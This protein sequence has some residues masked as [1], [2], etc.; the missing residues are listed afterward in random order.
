MSWKCKKCGQLNADWATTCGRC[1]SHRLDELLC[2]SD[3][4]CLESMQ[5]CEACPNDRSKKR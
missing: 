5:P 3:C 2:C 1:E 4:A